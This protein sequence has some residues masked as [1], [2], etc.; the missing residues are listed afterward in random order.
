VGF[1]SKFEKVLRKRQALLQFFGHPSD[2]RQYH[3]AETSFDRAVITPMQAPAFCGLFIVEL[4]TYGAAIFDAE[5]A[6]KLLIVLAIVFML[7]IAPSAIRASSSA[8]S[9]K[10]CPLWSCQRSFRRFVILPSS[11]A[12]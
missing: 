2:I 5:F 11:V 6:N 7:V 1:V 10:S 4:S 3:V 9:V 8:Y 12:V